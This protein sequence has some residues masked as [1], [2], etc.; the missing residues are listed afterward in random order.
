MRIAMLMVV[1]LLSF[2]AVG[3]MALA[4]VHSGGA[5]S[6]TPG[7]SPR[8]L[9]AESPAIR[10]AIVPEQDEG[11]IE[12]LAFSLDGKTILASNMHGVVHWFDL[13][14]GRKKMSHRVAPR[15]LGGCGGLAISRDGQLIATQ[16]NQN[17]VGLLDAVTGLPR[18]K[19]EKLSPQKRVFLRDATFAMNGRVV[20]GGYGSGEVVLWDTET[21]RRRVTLPPHSGPAYYSP[22]Y[23][24][25]RPGEP[26]PIQKLA[27]TPDEKS[28]VSFGGIVR[29]WDV[30]S[31]EERDRFEGNDR[32]QGWRMALSP[33]GNTLALIQNTGDPL[34]SYKGEIVLWDRSTKRRVAQWPIGGSGQDLAFLPDGKTLVSLEEVPIVRLWD[35]ATGKQRDAVRFDPHIHLVTLTVAPDGKR[36]ALGGYESNH[37]FGIINLLETDGITLQPWKPEP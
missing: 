17:E 32:P 27:V 16:T 11:S 15:Y 28:L 2:L 20:A 12:N 9:P 24:Q 30:A 3:V 14:T 26:D 21:G 18:L 22:A 25:V 13:A 29:I 37:I 33:D 23:K 6:S 31:G 34:T 4:G 8:E 35:V 1:S 7:D 19:L 10:C 5:A 36:I